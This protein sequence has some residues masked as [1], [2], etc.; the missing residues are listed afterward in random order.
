MAKTSIFN[1]DCHAEL[2][3]YT[4]N[5]LTYMMQ[6]QFIDKTKLELFLNEHIKDTGF[7]LNDNTGCTYMIKH[8]RV[9]RACNK[10]CKHGAPYC[11]DHMNDA[12]DSNISKIE[13]EYIC[14]NG[15]EYYYDRFTQNIFKYSKN[16]QYIGKLDSNT[17]TIISV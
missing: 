11:T 13:L 10:L 6:N 17:W 8:G 15:N 3:D 9:K 12:S 5:L 7:V 2:Q 16:P 4:L 1:A 14:I